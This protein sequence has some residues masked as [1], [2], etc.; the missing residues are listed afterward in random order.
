[1][2]ASITP[3]SKACTPSTSLTLLELATMGN[4]EAW[5]KIV[6]LYSPLVDGWCRMRFLSE[7]EI[8]EI[9]QDVF[10]KLFKKLG[11]FT[12]D[13]PEHGFRKWLW[14]LTR[15]TIFDHWRKLREEPQCV[16]GSAAQG[17][18]EDVADNPGRSESADEGT[19][20]LP[21]DRLIL[22]RRCFELLR[23]E[24]E[25]ATFQTFWEI[26]L[27]GK[28]PVDVARALG[29]KSVGAAYTARSRVMRRLRELL[30][31]LGEQMPLN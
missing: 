6:Y 29:L 26:A 30:D 25:P 4:R 16:G 12:K 3:S 10:L 20:K 8:A 23:S 19:L 2:S 14:I 5:E 15:N 22:L 21:S 7:D 11:K 13:E 24:F 27:N 28:A 1:M 17:M 18:M 9:G 31:Q